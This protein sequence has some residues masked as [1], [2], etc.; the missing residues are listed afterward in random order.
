MRQVRRWRAIRE[1]W[2][3][4]RKG[5][6]KRKQR[7]RSASRGRAQDEAGTGSAGSGRQ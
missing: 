5:E 4:V 2:K 1:L 3:K 7:G 6:S